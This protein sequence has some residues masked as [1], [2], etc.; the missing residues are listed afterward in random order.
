MPGL[1]YEQRMRMLRGHYGDTFCATVMLAA[2][3]DYA[4]RAEI[5][6]RVGV[7]RQ[8]VKQILE[9]ADARGILAM[10]FRRYP[11]RAAGLERRRAAK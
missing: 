8:R 10:P 5:A 9:T 1:T 3:G 11:R 6:R 7:C 4:S 2:S